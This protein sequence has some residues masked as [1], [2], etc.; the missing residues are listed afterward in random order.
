VAHGEQLGPFGLAG[1]M[2]ARSVPGLPRRMAAGLTV[3]PAT[4]R[5]QI[6]CA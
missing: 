5:L 4:P 6:A 2:A 1:E 3:Q